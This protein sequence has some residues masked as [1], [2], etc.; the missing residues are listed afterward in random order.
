MDGASH[1]TKKKFFCDNMPALLARLR[2]TRH[3]KYALVAKDYDYFCNDMLSYEREVKL[4]NWFMSLFGHD[5]TGNRVLAFPPTSPGTGGRR[6]RTTKKRHHWS[7]KYK[8]SINCKR[9][10]GFSQRQYCKYGRNKK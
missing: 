10:R 7:Q 2:A 8:R 1:Q 4:I 9:P 5:D 3:P 6:T